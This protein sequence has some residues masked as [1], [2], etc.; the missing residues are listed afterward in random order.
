M[1]EWWTLRRNSQSLRFSSGDD[2]RHRM[3]RLSELGMGRVF[4]SEHSRFSR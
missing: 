3:I 1:L 4:E 2:S